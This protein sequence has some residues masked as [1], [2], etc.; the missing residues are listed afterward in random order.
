MLRFGLK[1][2][3]G[4]IFKG[5]SDLR[6]VVRVQWAEQHRALWQ[7]TRTL[8]LFCCTCGFAKSTKGHRQSFCYCACL[9]S[10]KEITSPWV[11]VHVWKP[12]SA[13][14]SLLY[15]KSHRI[16]QLSGHCLHV[17]DKK[18]PLSDHAC[19][20]SVC[21]SIFIYILSIYTLGFRAGHRLACSMRHAD[22][23]AHPQRSKVSINHSILIVMVPNIRT[24]GL[25]TNSHQK[26]LFV[27]AEITSDA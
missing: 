22:S 10:R 2:V 13:P 3:W 1:L 26:M 6:W 24:I 16:L 17:Q 9:A 23:H 27:A 20:Q 12:V 5:V 4:G 15:N 7:H 21:E 11:C 25:Q 14:T 8:S 18:Y 19:W